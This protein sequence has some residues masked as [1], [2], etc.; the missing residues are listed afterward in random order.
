MGIYIPD[1]EMPTSCRQC[2]LKDSWH[3]RCKLTNT[4]WNFSLRGRLRNCPLIEMEKE[5]ERDN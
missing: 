5:N 3:D 2:L 4:T 1:E